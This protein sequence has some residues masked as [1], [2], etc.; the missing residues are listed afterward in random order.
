MMRVITRILGLTVL[1]LSFANGAS[2]GMISG[3]VKG[4]AGAPFRGAFVQ[5]RN[6][7]TRMTV[8][9]LSDSQG[10]Y[11]VRNLP[12]GAYELRAKAIGYGDDQR[13]EV[14]VADGKSLHMDF[15]LQNGKVRW[16][17]L[18]SH[19]G[20][21]LLPEGKGKEVLMGKCFACHQFQSRIAAKAP[22]NAAG[23]AAGIE[24]MRRTIK[25]RMRNVT[26]AD[27]A[28]MTAYL[29]KHFGPNSEL[30][31][32]S[33]MPGYSEL[34]RPVSDEAL[35]MVYV[36]YE[37]PMPN[38]FPWSAAPDN[39]G[40]F[41]IPFFGAANRI[42]RLD[43]ATGEVEEFAVPFQ[44]NAAGVHSTFP[45]PDGAVWLGE[46]GT[47]RIGRWDPVTRKITEY[48]DTDGGG[49]V[50]VRVNQ[51]GIVWGSG[52]LSRF[53]PKTGQF[54][55]Y[56]E[57]PSSYSI[58]IDKDGNAWFSVLADG[59]SIGRADAKTGKVTRWA[60]PTP[61]AY[62][63]RMAFDSQGFLWFGEYRSG[64]IGRFDPKT[65]TFQE[66]PLPGANPTPYALNVDR[67]DRIWYSSMDMN[68][69]GRLDPKTGKVIEYPFPYSENTMREFFLDSQ[70]RMW[71]GSPA[72][73]RV[74]YF[75]PSNLQ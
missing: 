53:D 47:N 17:D 7:E 29:T 56:P 23:W 28:E 12:P 59:N 60:P 15:S 68:V 31:S 21:K 26:D 50:T 48:V 52:K 43:P 14:N 4:P 41:W 33:D 32:P 62:P 75:M 16:S 11:Q 58:S 13:S 30:P 74:G 46:Q 6:P 70:G 63:R 45:T 73:N 72:N 8:S 67:N 51:E 5:A 71:F 37:M 42:G 49:K 25:Y 34:V 69:V 35:N 57:I 22:R 40:N 10:R 27:A 55:H 61:N 24:M 9:V 38:R 36:D 18:T 64:K 2:D 65:E 20:K 44:E 54:T 19:Q 3:T 39:K 66:Y 1:S